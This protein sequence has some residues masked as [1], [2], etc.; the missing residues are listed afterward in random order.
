MSGMQMKSQ[1]Q[2]PHRCEFQASNKHLR[3]L[4]TLKIM[5][6]SRVLR[7]SSGTVPNDVVIQPVNAI[8]GNGGV[9]LNVA[10]QPSNPAKEGHLLHLSYLAGEVR[11]KKSL[12]HFFSRAK[13]LLCPI[14]SGLTK[15]NFF[16]RDR[17]TR[18]FRYESFWG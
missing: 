1:F 18:K 10:K 14:F 16:L 17:E 12:N 2:L 3:V 4:F 5:Q 7:E 9:E 15:R 6:W 11:K 13:S 8:A